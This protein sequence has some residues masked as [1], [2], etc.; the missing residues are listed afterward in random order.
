M[1]FMSSVGEALD[2]YFGITERGSTVATEF[3]GGIITFLAMVY[4]LTVNPAVVSVGAGSSVSIDALFT[5]TAIAAVIS[6]LIMGL[7][8]KFP[9]ALAPG[10]GVNAFLS[11]TICITMGFSYVQALLA[12][13]FSGILFF[14]LSVTGA[15]TKMMQAFPSV[16]R[17]AFTAGIGL[18]ISIIGLF[19]AN[20]IVHAANSNLLAL[21]DLG[22]KAVLLALFSIVITFVFWFRKNWM[23]VLIGIIATTVLGLVLGVTSLPSE[24]VTTPDFSLFGALFDGFTDLGSSNLTSFIAIILA[25]TVLDLFDTTGTIMAVASRAKNA[26]GVE[27]ELT[28]RPLMADSVATVTGALCGIGSTTSYIE[29]CT[30]IESGARTGLMAVVTGLMFMV[31]L[32][33]CPVFSIVTYSCVTGA[34]VL[35]G[36][37]MVSSVREIDWNDRICAATAF[38]TIAFTGL[39]G[40]IT[41]GMAF[42]I[43]TYIIG[44]FCMGKIREVSRVLFVVAGVFLMYL[45]LYYGYIM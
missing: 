14:V 42:G 15:R 33:F 31:A 40:S 6:C 29:S 44:M 4:V 43:F 25:L 41:N 45:V 8:A 9:L 20:I 21:G 16:I 19:N 23:A 11:Y 7:Y 35:V 38:M 27:I 36:V 3:K 37:L 13:L 2:R 34:L 10:V 28:D 5:S 22:D 1:P 24:Y 26:S 30:G 18:F 32:F 17:Y 12:V 39:S